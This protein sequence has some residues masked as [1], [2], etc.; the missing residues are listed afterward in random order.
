LQWLVSEPRSDFKPIGRPRRSDGAGTKLH[1]SQSH[2]DVLRA[3]GSA[4]LAKERLEGQDAHRSVDLRKRTCRR[5]I[6]SLNNDAAVAIIGETHKTGV[7]ATAANRCEKY[8]HTT[9]DTPENPGKALGAF[10]S[11]P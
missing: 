1:G 2:K 5:R 9:T 11:G 3:R 10:K 6:T 4:E 8:G 7:A